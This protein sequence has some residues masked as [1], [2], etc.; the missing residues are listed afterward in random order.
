MLLL[1]PQYSARHRA[2]YVARHRAGPPAGALASACRRLPRAVALPTIAVVALTC[3]G[4]AAAQQGR[5]TD[6]NGFTARDLSASASSTSS[7]RA[8]AFAAGGTVA[9]G[10]SG[11]SA[12]AYEASLA[13]ATQQA[14]ARADSAAGVARA[15]PRTSLEARR[16]RAARGWQLPVRDYVLTSG[17]GMRWG[18]LH[19]G[20]DFAVPVGTPIGALSSGTVNF[21]GNQGGYGNKVE[22]RYW[23]GTV[24]YFGHMSRIDVTTGQPV[25]G[26]Q[27]VGG[28]GNTGHS[29]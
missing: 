8:T 2:P 6:G 22:I 13:A 26:G 14:L 16:L 4:A 12:S 18:R 23:D 3:G 7:A 29:T 5:S 28:S 11:A 10:A 27:V 17:F 25:Q 24:S 1:A 15:Q 19:A 20:E 21:A 9:S